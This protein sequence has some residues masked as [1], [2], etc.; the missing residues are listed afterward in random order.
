MTT[1]VLIKNP[2]GNH[3]NIRVQTVDTDGTI[4]I[5]QVLVEGQETELYVYKG[6]EIL[7]QEV[8]EP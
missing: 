4:S 6:R 3:E 8:R 5:E 7:I 1:R 2:D